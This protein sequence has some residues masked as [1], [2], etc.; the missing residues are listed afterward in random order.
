MLVSLLYR[1]LVVLLGVLVRRGGERE[2]E[3]LILRH[4]L[5]ILGRG[6]R[7][8]QYTTSDRALLAAASRLLPPDCRSSF[9]VSTQTLHRWHRALL[10]S[11]RI[12]PRAIGR[13]PLAAAIRGL[14]ERLARENPSWGYMRI[15]GELKGLGISVS[16]TTVANVL[17][18][19]GLGPAPRRI[20]PSWSQFL[21]AQAESLVNGGL[22]SRLADGLNDEAC[23]ATRPRDDGPAATVG[24]AAE[25]AP[26]AQPRTLAQLRPMRDRPPLAPPRAS[27][28]L[29]RPSR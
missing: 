22:D 4:Q 17:R 29:R 14:I 11:R 15:Q 28:P 26:A 23:T 16:A 20:G 19:A 3:I 9:L 18:R 25:C 5:A 13:P 8:P 27:S 7:R 12:A 24:A 6:G 10:R 2:L 21:R 1:L